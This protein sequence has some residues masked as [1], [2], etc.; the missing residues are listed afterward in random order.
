M[1]MKRRGRL[2]VKP[3][4]ARAASLENDLHKDAM[5]KRSNGH[6]VKLKSDHIIKCWRDAL[7]GRVVYIPQTTLPLTQ[8]RRPVL[9]ITHKQERPKN[10]PG[11]NENYWGDATRSHQTN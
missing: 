2:Q 6:A 10:T 9:P 5:D 3:G 11:R 8:E 7:A 4:E 1:K